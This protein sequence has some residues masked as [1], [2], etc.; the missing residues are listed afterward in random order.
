MGYS[1]HIENLTMVYLTKVLKLFENTLLLKNMTA[2][3]Y[4]IT[5][6]VCNQ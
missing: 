2:K 1:F 4:E 3:A 6:C 5:N